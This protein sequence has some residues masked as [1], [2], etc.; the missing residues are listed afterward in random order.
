MTD[1]PADKMVALL[2]LAKDQAARNRH[3]LFE[4]IADLFLSSEG[5]LTERERALMTDILGKLIDD[6]EAE[7]R[8]TLAERMAVL[9]WAP[10]DLV[11]RLAEDEAAVARPLLLHSTVLKDADLIDLVRQRSQEHRLAIAMRSGIGA[12]VSD[13]LIEAGE[14]DVIEALIRNQDA[15]LSRQ[16]IDYLVEESRRVDRFQEPLLR[17]QEL[18]PQ[19]AFRMFWWVSAALR[20]RILSDFPVSETDLDD[21][22]ESSVYAS[23]AKVEAGEAEAAKLAAR[24]YERG[25]L[26]V[27]SIIQSLRMGH[28]GA[29]LAGL[30]RLAGIDPGTCRRIVFA[31]GG[32]ALVAC[33]K[34]AGFDRSAFATVFLLSREARERAGTLPTA[35]VDN[36]LELFDKTDIEQARGALRYWMRDAGYLGAIAALDQIPAPAAS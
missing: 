8:R 7:V 33:C 30:S 4:N 9:P 16:A 19:L 11:L 21:V 32:E 3:Q 27:R 14:G 2:G 6:V 36:M 15:H 28:T 12:A 18:P 34:A 5:R 31:P 29:F 35:V 24:M 26:S 23:I 1:S 22:I 20:R 17:R 13:A 10:R 25:E